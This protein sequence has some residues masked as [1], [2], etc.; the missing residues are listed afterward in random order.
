MPTIALIVLNYNGK[1]FLGPCLASITRQTLAPDELILV[2]NGSTDGSQDWITANYPQAK[3]VEMGYNSGFSIAM[4]RGVAESS[5]DFLALL[6]NDTE[7]EPQWLEQLAGALSQHP[8]IGFCAS[9]MLIFQHRDLIDAAG[10]V[11]T[12]AAF[13]GKR[14]WLQSERDMKFDKRERVFG[15]CAGAAMYRKVIFEEVGGFDDDFFAY[16][17]DTDLSLRLQLAGYPCLYVPEA[18]VYH[19]VGGTSKK[20]KYGFSIRL[21]Q[22][23]Q[24]LLLVKNLPSGFYIRFGLPILLGHFCLFLMRI[25]RGYGTSAILGLWDALRGLRTALRKRKRIQENRRVTNAY[26]IS[27]MRKDWIRLLFEPFLQ[28]RNLKRQNVEI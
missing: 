26:L 2:D 14:G 4:N 11:F 6:N 16:Q 3:L 7:C 18:V 5:S 10:D 23:N 25:K 20:Q 13:A 15:A 27:A 8:E 1:H 21:E 22:R 19:H 28:K 12:T 9:R 24:I 17:E